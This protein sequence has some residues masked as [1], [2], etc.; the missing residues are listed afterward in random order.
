MET[1]GGRKIEVLT[2][3]HCDVV[4]KDNKS[5]SNS[6]PEELCCCSFKIAYISALILVTVTVSFGNQIMP[7]RLF[8][9][10]E[11]EIYV[12]VTEFI[13]KLKKHRIK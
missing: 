8:N 1:L 9:T 13:R 6:E 3:P 2:N 10:I 12:F 4:N 5:I 11:L 7:F